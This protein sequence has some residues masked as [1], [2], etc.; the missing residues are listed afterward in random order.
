MFPVPGLIPSRGAA[1]LGRSN[2]TP[3]QVV[4]TAYRNGS[5]FHI[6][7]V[8]TIYSQTGWYHSLCALPGAGMVIKMPDDPSEIPE[9]NVRSEHMQF[10]SEALANKRDISGLRTTYNGI[11]VT[12]LREYLSMPMRKRPK[13]KGIFAKIRDSFS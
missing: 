5:Y 6:P 4:L 7:G 13:P 9:R 8:E 2:S 10:L 3:I 1:V 11:T 12:S